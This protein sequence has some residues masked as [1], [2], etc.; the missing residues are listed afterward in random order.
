MTH[1]RRALAL[2]AAALVLPASAL[3]ATTKTVSVKDDFFKAK[4]VTISKGSKVKWVWRGKAP[5]NVTVAKGPVKFRSSTKTSGTYTRTFK[6]K[7]TYRILCSIHAPDMK[8][9]VTVR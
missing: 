7:G 5:H 1:P 2:A 4:S 6:K 3:A 8:M 9:T